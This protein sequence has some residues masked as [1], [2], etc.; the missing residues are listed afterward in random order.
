[1]TETGPLDAVETQPVDIE[2]VP[3]PPSSTKP[4]DDSPDPS[5]AARRAQ[6]QNRVLR[7]SP[8]LPYHPYSPEVLDDKASGSKDKAPV[9]TPE[10]D[11][12]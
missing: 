11:W 7:K 9:F 2:G 3:T 8:T 10:K 1:M 12:V 4:R 6:Y 5:S